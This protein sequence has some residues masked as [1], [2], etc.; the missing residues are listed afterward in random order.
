MQPMYRP[1][2]L[3]PTSG[4]GLQNCHT[5]WCL[6][7]CVSNVDANVV[8]SYIWLIYY[9]HTIPV[10][11]YISTQPMYGPMQLALTLTYQLQIHHTHWHL[12]WYVT[13]VGT[14][15]VG[16]YTSI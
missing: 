4:C 9:K 10:G 15:G 2:Q 1:M 8:G 5:R 12:H 6:H 11:V 3:A 14:S 7:W 13:N 16:T